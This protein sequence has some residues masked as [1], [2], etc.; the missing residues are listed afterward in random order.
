MK[1]KELICELCNRPLSNEEAADH[2]SA[3]I[4]T[5]HCYHCDP[6]RKQDIADF[7]QDM[8]EIHTIESLQHTNGV[9]HRRAAE[10][11]P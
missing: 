9:F 10:E 2:Y 8:Q 11:S 4:T 1:P 5:F 6:A 7:H 3:P